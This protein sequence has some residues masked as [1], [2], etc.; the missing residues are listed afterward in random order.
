MLCIYIFHTTRGRTLYIFAS[1]YP[2]RFPWES[3]NTGRE[4]TQPCCPL[5]AQKQQ[6]VTADIAFAIRNHFAATNDLAWLQREGCPLVREIA[7]FWAS[8]VQFNTSTQL[9]DIRGNLQIS[10]AFKNVYS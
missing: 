10:I 4:V 5:V 9:Y 2:Y 1:T 3:A 6:H 8:R 7:T